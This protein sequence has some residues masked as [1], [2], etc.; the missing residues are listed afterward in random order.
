MDLIE[1]PR[2]CFKNSAGQ[3]IHLREIEQSREQTLTLLRVHISL[4]SETPQSMAS[5]LITDD[6]ADLQTSLMHG[7]EKL[8]RLPVQDGNCQHSE[9]LQFKLLRLLQKSFHEGL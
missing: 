5:I 8:L 4:Q 3:W 2:E 1:A 6:S 7:H 9:T